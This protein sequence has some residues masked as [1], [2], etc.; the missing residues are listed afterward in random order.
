[1]D[2]RKTLIT[3]I[4]A[5]TIGLTSYATDLLVKPGA[6]SIEKA[7]QQ[8]REERR[9]NNATDICLRLQEG[10]YQLNQPI[11]I[12]P[13]DNGTRIVAD[14]KV[15]ISGGVSI[16]GWKKEGKC[17]VADVPDFNGRPL[18]FRQLW[19]NGKKAV[20]ARD[21]DDFEQMF[22]IRSVDKANE[23]IYVP[24][25]AVKKIINA[26]YPEMVLHEMWCIA[27]LR[28][29]NIKIQGDSAAVTFHQPESHVHFMH[30]WPSPMVTTDGHNS[31]FYLTNAKELLDSEGEWYLDARASKLYYIPRKGEDMGSAEVIAP[32]VETLV[33]VAG[34]PD[35]PVKDVTFEGITFSYATWM[36]PSVSGHAPLQAGMYMTEA[37][38]LRPKMDRPNGDHK[39][40]NQGWVGRPAAAVS[41]N[42]AENVSFTKCTFEHN[43][44]TGLDYHLYI[45]GGT[46]DRCT[47][48]DIGG[49]GILAGGF[50]PEG[51]EAHKPYDPA[52]R[53]IICTGL[54]ITNNLITDVTNEDWGCV[55]IGAGFV[56]DIRICNNEIS[57][58]SYTGISVGWG[59][60][61]Q[62]CSMA[63]N[64][65]S[66]NLIYNYAK[67][68]YDT[69]GIYTLGAQPHSLIEGNVVR[70]IYT[71]SYVHDPEHWFYLYTDEGSSGITVRN[72]WTPAEKYL[73]NANGPGNTWGNNGPAVADSIKANAGIRK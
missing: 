52:D 40:D 26:K 10:V 38:K 41:L 42:C 27:N 6:Y 2:T 60:N 33:Q 66:G 9:L 37:Y 46:V 18:E 51:F 39:L 59:W 53:R 25:K 73:K 72:N 67:H 12:R 20:R 35:E 48:R 56:R 15:T 7:L 19:V 64:L 16:S 45:K 17:Y 28:I 32:A 21:V 47:F 57:D 23:T 22:R 30:P 55:G 34:T 4:F 71:P 14:G 70:D 13:E 68:M 3:S 5:V 43:A 62:P 50:S 63:N 58:V 8:A 54:N 31:A 24:A 36:R 61:Q 1:M 65:I 44:S 69:A 11:T 29:K 49:N